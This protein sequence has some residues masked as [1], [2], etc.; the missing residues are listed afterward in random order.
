MSMFSGLFGGSLL[1]K[2]DGEAA[3]SLF[4][5][6]SKYRRQTPAGSQASRQGVERKAKQ[7][8]R[9]DLAAA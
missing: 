6:A 2:G 1:E 3:G 5:A 7:K 4:A 9:V 8:K